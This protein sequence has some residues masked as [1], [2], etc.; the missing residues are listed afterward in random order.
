MDRIQSAI[1]KARA[2]RAAGTDIQR[3][4]RPDPHPAPRHGALP[5]PA[6]GAAARTAE[7]EAAALWAALPEFRP[8]PAALREARVVTGAAG[9]LAI[10]FDVMRTKLLHQLR[11]H[12]WRRVAITSPGVSCGKTMTAAN[13]AFSLARQSDLYTMLIEL[14]LRRPAMASVLGV[15]ERHLF[16]AALEG[17]SAPE[18]H[19]LRYGQNLA[20]ATNYR[21]SHN[22]AE[23][24][25]GVGAARVLDTLEARYRPDAVIF[26]M[27]PMLVSDDTMAFLDQVDACLLVAAAGETTTDEIDRC[28]QEIATRTNLM[29]VILNKCRFQ[30][31]TVDYGY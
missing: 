24:L 1:E 26:D 22:P 31:K 27:P 15:K 3:E 17:G 13:L 2:R 11:S 19:L 7:A 21:A 14:D 23:L 25:Q 5:D 30:E 28:S 4:P 9:L 8:D 12:G 18:E 16:A 10:P 6:A 29:G 20:I